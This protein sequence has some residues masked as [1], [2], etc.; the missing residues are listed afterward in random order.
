MI[1][2]LL[3][4]HECPLYLAKKFPGGEP[5]IRFEKEA[6][7]KLVSLTFQIP[8][9]DYPLI[10]HAVDAVRRINPVLDI[11]LYI[12]YFPGARQ[13][14]VCLDGEPLG[15]KVYADMINRLAVASV[16]I[17]DPHSDVISALIDR[18]RVIP[19]GTVPTPNGGFKEIIPDFKVGDSFFVV[20]PDTGAR[21][22]V[23]AAVSRA[24]KLV[25]KD[26]TIHFAQG[27][28]IRDLSTGKLSGFS[29]DVENFGGRKV[30]IMDDINCNGGTFIGLAEEL[31]K[32]GAGDVILFTT[33]TDHV[34]GIV[35]VLTSGFVN[36]VLTT[37]SRLLPLQDCD[38]F[39][40]EYLRIF[41]VFFNEEAQQL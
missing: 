31:K 22:K 20:A 4:D 16:T 17:L 9:F 24:E 26:A 37:N 2:T 12:P 10:A 30:L 13:D 8:V 38:P 34:P 14:R 32:R 3:A 23:L 35:N 33:H 11:H 29:V 25:G 19:Q 5:F 28:K 15:A 27:E 21:K 7:R 6:I 39:V 41:D 18:V 40:V 1:T 36:L